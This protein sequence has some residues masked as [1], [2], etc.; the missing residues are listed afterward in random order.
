MYFWG[1]GFAVECE[2]SENIDMGLLI[3]I[4]NA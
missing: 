3:L 4:E 1:F 2:Y